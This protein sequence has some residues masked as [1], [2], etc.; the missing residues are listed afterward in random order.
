[1]NLTNTLNVPVI[2]SNTHD[3]KTYKRVSKGAF[4][5][6]HCSDRELEIMTNLNCGELA[7]REITRR[8]N[9]DSISKSA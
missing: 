2:N 7:Q 4:N 8:S 5:M 6:T 1:M 9:R 3:T